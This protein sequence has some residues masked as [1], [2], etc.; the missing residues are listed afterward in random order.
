[1]EVWY[2]RETLTMNLSSYDDCPQRLV[3]CTYT[4]GLPED[5]ITERIL[6]VG[7]NKPGCMEESVCRYECCGVE[8]Y[9]SEGK[10]WTNEVDVVSQEQTGNITLLFRNCFAIKCVGFLQ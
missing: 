4:R 9:M 6:L 10:T 3:P 8:L 7:M 1:M 2:K 5:V